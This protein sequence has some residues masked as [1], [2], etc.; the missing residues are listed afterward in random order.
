MKKQQLNEVNNLLKTTQLMSGRFNPKSDSQLNAISMIF[1][2][3]IY[4]C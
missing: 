2:L 4:L 3:A 1:L